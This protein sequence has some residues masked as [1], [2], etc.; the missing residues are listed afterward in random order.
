MGYHRRRVPQP[1]GRVLVV[2]LDARTPGTVISVDHDGRA[3]E[4]ELEDGERLQFRLVPATGTFRA[5]DPSR[6]RLLFE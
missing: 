1:G 3:V 2:F 6:A 5:L 4:V